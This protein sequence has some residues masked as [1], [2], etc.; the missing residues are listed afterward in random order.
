MD[1]IE[2][3]PDF[4]RADGNIYDNLLLA[5]AVMPPTAST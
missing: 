3:K 2:F 5:E 4:V 1:E